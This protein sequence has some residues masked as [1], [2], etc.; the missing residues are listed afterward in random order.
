MTYSPA[1]EQ[2]YCKPH[3]I[4]KISPLSPAMCRNFHR[5]L[6]NRP[7][8]FCACTARAKYHPKCCKFAKI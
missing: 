5:K 2:K 4:V 7:S 8:C 6:I 1:V 3:M